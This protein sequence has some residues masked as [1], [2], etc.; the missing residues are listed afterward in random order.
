MVEIW[1]IGTFNRALIHL[2][3]SDKTGFADGHRTPAPWQ[4][5]CRAIPQNRAK[6]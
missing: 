4:Y 5:L 3:V 1:W 2:T 6:T